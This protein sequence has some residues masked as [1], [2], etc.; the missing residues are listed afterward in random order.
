MWIIR[1]MQK[2]D[3]V[4]IAGLEKQCFTDPWSEISVESELNNPLSYWLVAVVDGNVVAYIGSQ[5]V[6]DSADMMNLAVL[7]AYRRQGIGEKLVAALQEQLQ[8]KGSLSLALEVRVSNENAIS[9][10]KKMGFVQVGLRPNYYRNPKE[11]AYILRK[12]LG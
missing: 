5:S 8:E 9:L 6:L 4:A 12:E 11:D 7:P 2:S 10:Y 1:K 3:I